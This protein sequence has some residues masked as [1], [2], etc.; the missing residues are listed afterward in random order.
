[1]REDRLN[2]SMLSLM[3]LVVSL[4]SFGCD[5]APTPVSPEF[6]EQAIL[7]AMEEAIQ[8]EYRAELIYERVLADFG[9]VRPFLNI[10][11]A[12]VRHS[13]SLARLFQARG[14]QVPVSKWSPDEIPGFPSVSDACKA[15]AEAEIE[16]A[17][18]YERYFDLELPADVRQ[19]FENNRRASVENHLR[20]FQRCF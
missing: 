4:G 1:M 8:D 18:I 3:A 6:Q 17:K 20:A 16:N 13:E 14:L 7:A 11:Q 9:P 5:S 10:V 19:V 15:G 2:M 12:E